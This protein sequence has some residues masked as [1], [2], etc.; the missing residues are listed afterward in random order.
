MPSPGNSCFKDFNEAFGFMTRAALVAEKLDHH[1]EWFNVYKTVDGDALDPR[2]RRPDRARREARPGNEPAAGADAALRPRAAMAIWRDWQ[3][4][5][6]LRLRG[7]VRVLVRSRTSRRQRPACCRRRDMRRPRA[8]WEGLDERTA[9]R[10]ARDEARVRRGF[11]SKAKRVAARLPFAE[12]LLAAYYCAFDRTTPL[13]VK[14]ALLGALAY[15]VLPFDRRSRHAAASRLYATTPPC[16]SRR[17]GWLP[18][19]IRPEHREAARQALAR[20][21]ATS[22][23]THAAMAKSDLRA[24]PGGARAGGRGGGGALIARASS[25]RP[26]RSA[27]ACC[28]RSL[29]GS[30][31]CIS[32]ACIKLQSGKAGAACAHLE[33][34]L[35]LNPASAQVMSNLG[36]TLAALN[37]D[38]GGAGDP[39]QGGRAHA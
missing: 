11:W 26:R 20:G 14:A 22:T 8:A 34:A 37:R 10:A 5:Q 16:W 39:R 21:L 18:S 3:A 24:N 6:G 31:R 33:Q 23:D 1:P 15:F 30:T 12:D 29:I 19:H 4:R 13:Q 38:A 35:K 25:T 32:W 7:S 17:C 9:R 2:C 27:P 36:M 28:A